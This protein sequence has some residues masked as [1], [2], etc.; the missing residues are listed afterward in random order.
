MIAILALLAAVAPDATVRTLA[1]MPV[2]SGTEV[3]IGVDGDVR[4]RDF[5]LSGPDRIVI[6]LHG[7]Q[8]AL[9]AERFTAIERGGVRSVRTSQYQRDVVRVVL[10]VSGPLDY[11][12]RRERD[13][14]YVTFVNPGSPFEAWTVGGPPPSLQATERRATEP[15]ML[16]APAAVQAPQIPQ[17]PRITVSFEAAPILEVIQTFA[18]FSGR[19]IIP[20]ANVTGEITADIYDQPWDEALEALLEAHGYTLVARPNGILQVVQLAQLRQR[21]EVE[22]LVTR[23]F[24]IKY[25]S[26]DSLRP[27]IEG[28][29]SSRGKITTSP[30]TNTLIITDGTSVLERIEPLLEELDAKTPQVTIAAKLIFVDRTALEE[31]GVVYDLKD[32]Q[33]SQLNRVVSGFVDRNNNGIFEPD[34][35]TT[36]DVIALGGSSVAALAN[37]QSRVASPTLRLVTTLL[38]GRHSLITFIDA[39]ESLQLSDIQATPVVTVL[40]NREARIQVGEETPIRTIDAGAGGGQGGGFPVA[41]VSFR[42]TGVILRVTPHV[43]GDQVLLELHAERSNIA[44]AP[45]DLGVTFQT[46]ESDTQVLVRDGE[47]AVIGGLTIIE[48]TQSRSGIPFLMDLPVLGRLFATTTEREVKRDLMIMVTPHIVREGA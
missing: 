46:Q 36:Q 20:G 27:A 38:L 11:R 24:R 18:A 23:N 32:S 14:V 9:P 42:E 5:A 31:L 1:V 3:I 16:P 44:A 37:A 12:V 34:E 7:A 41:T 33:G 47:T 22:N 28:L 2:E 8:H 6:D 26:V 4:V 30:S 29:L 17:E 43:T 10:E 15:R 19:S 45:S 13:G 35:A 40:D 48:K 21:E 25:V 39:L